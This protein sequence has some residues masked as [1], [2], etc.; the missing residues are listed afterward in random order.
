VADNTRP[1]PIALERRDRLFGGSK[2]GAYRN[3]CRQD[4]RGRQRNVA[5]SI[6]LW[7]PPPGFL[8]DVR[9]FHQN[10]HSLARV[11]FRYAPLADTFG[12]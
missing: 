8:R 3:D 7:I 11:A 10:G 9:T 6:H 2:Q 12:H 1:L 5:M 4:K